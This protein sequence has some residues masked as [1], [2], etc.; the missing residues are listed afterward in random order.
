VGDTAFIHVQMNKEFDDL[1][2][3]LISRGTV[4][5]WDTASFP[6]L[7]KNHTIS[8]P[9]DPATE[10]EA[11]LIVY[12]VLPQR[13]DVIAESLKLEVQGL[14]SRKI[15]I[16]LAGNNKSVEPGTNVSISCEG[17]WPQSLLAIRAVDQ[18]VLLLKE[19]KD[20]DA[21]TLG[22]LK[23]NYLRIIKNKIK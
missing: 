14:E 6:E 16:S 3:V 11:H 2:W 10:P 4:L 17:V 13:E 18:S 8:I 1:K 5:K 23:K 12:T 7:A 9:L 22:L 20:I 21:K 19:D 15:R